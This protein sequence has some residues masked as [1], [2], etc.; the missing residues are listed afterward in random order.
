MARGEPYYVCYNCGKLCHYLEMHTC[1]V[2]R[3]TTSLTSMAD[4]N[5]TIPIQP[6][7]EAPLT[8]NVVSRE[9]GHI[10]SPYELED[11][12]CEFEQW[13]NCSDEALFTFEASLEPEV[14]GYA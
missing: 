14:Y 13:D 2:G 6:K 10:V 7:R 5:Y 9:K 3:D 12:W 1:L 8:L 11:L 4:S